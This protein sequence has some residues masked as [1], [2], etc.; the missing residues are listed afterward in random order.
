MASR[1]AQ[2]IASDGVA[3]AVVDPARDQTRAT[4]ENE[5]DDDVEAQVIEH[6]QGRL[7]RYPG[8]DR[9]QP[10]ANKWRRDG[11]ADQLENQVAQWHLAR[12]D[13]GVQCGEHRQQAAAQIGAQHQAKCNVDGDHAAGGQCGGQQNNRQTGVGHHCQHRPDRDFEQQVTA[14]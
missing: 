9:L 13:V 3:S 5:H 1:T 11:N 10:Q 8:A 4:D 14:E 6:D 12:L 2:E 7:I